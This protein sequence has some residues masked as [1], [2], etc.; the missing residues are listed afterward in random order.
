MMEA[1]DSKAFIDTFN[2]FGP[3]VVCV[4]LELIAQW[5]LW[6]TDKKNKL[7]KLPDVSLFV[8]RLDDKT[9]LSGEAER[10]RV[11]HC[12]STN[13]GDETDSNFTAGQTV[14]GRTE[15]KVHRKETF[16]L[17]KR[18]TRKENRKTYQTRM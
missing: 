16:T 8:D 15:E 10:V 5:R 7:P 1:V 14:P 4:A 6:Q 13:I 9:D 2:E 18:V 17:E 3:Q 12:S 11:V